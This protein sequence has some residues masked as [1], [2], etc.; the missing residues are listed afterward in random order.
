MPAVWEYFTISEKDQQYAVCTTC[1]SE[2]S[3]EGTS[4]KDFNTSNF[5]THLKKRHEAAYNGYL[6]ANKKRRE[7]LPTK[8][9]QYTTGKTESLINTSFEK[10][11]KFPMDS[12]KAKGIT[13]KVI[14]F[15]VFDDQPFS[16]V[17]DVGFQSLME[18]MEPCYAL[19]SRR[20]FAEV[21]LPEIYNAMATH[22]HELL[23]CDIPAISF[24]T[25]IWSS[26]NS[27]M[28][29][30]SLTAQWIDKDFNLIKAVLHSQEFTGS[31]STSA[32]SEAFE[33]MF[34]TWNIVR[35]NVK[36]MTKAMMDSDL[37]GSGCMAH[38]SWL[39]MKAF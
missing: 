29:K 30:L 11:K 13:N 16:V 7:D 32:I 12:A 20:H 22:I 14:E 5:I 28:S 24:T 3:R 26:D 4:S 23:A 10:G 36:N 8:R 15:L 37:A 18:Y 33:K 34:Q 9:A 1:S 19:P 17:E 35:D 25:G 21:C 31:H 38:C 6:K 2:I 39:S 27:P